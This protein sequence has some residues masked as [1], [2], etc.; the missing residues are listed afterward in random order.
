ME[1]YD[2]CSV[3]L[4]TGYPLIQRFEGQASADIL[5]RSYLTILDAAAQTE[6]SPIKVCRGVT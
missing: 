5:E 2:G 1:E 6:L 4:Y 3:P